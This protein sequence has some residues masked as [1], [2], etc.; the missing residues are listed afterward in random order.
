[1]ANISVSAN[2]EDRKSIIDAIYVLM[3]AGQVNLDMLAPAHNS[4]QQPINQH[5]EA[6]A[7]AAIVTLTIEDVRTALKAFSQKHGRDKAVAILNRAGYKTLDDVPAEAY[8]SIVKAT[9]A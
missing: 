1:M 5:E 7:E 4:R 9:E 8:E 2:S 3:R 6:K